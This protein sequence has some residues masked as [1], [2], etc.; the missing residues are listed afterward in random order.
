MLCLCDVFREVGTIDDRLKDIKSTQY[1]CE[2]SI[3]T[4]INAVFSES[5]KTYIGEE[6]VRN[7]GEWG[8]L[9][10]KIFLF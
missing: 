2:R 1:V 3:Q 7:K 8:D 9:Q 5:E 6:I 10:R 4:A